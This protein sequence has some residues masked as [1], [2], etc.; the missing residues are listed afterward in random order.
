VNVTR[1]NEKQKS[2]Q[3]TRE[4]GIGI[5]QKKRKSTKTNHQGCWGWNSPTITT[6]RQKPEYSRVTVSAPSRHHSVFFAS[7]FLSQQKNEVRGCW[8][9]DS[10]QLNTNYC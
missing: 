4:L 1:E 5:Q 9:A 10:P 8:G 6:K 7:F 2:K 3:I